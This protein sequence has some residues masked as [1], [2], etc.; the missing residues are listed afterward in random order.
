MSGFLGPI[1]GAISGV[2][3]VVGATGSLVNDVARIGQSFGGSQTPDTSGVSWASGSWFQQLQPGS[4][5]GVGFV[6]D[7]GDTAAGRRVAIHEYPYRDDAWAE[8]LG[9]LPRR[10]TI[11]AFMVG[12][13]C[14]AQ[15]DAMLKACEQSGAGTLVH[16]TLGSIQCVLL[17]F[18]CADRRE[19]GRVVE[20]QFAFILAGAVLYPA[21]AIATGQN[22]LAAAGALNLASASDLGSTL[23]SIGNVANEVTSTVS[24]YAGIA[25]GIVG[26]ATRIFNSVRGLTGFYGRYATG[27]RSVL[28][29]A[30]ATIQGVLGAATTARTLVN[31]TAALV[32]T[33]ASFL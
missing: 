26:D 17:E 13:D 8:D 19:R 6:L 15:R 30:N 12:D 3:R 23:Q 29:D 28:Q 1:A 32:N 4:W 22:V 11:Q 24:H 9:K 25:T 31:N 20:L 2:N 27:S 33:A 10:F 7:A 14:Y 16:P 21:T 18:S 5:R